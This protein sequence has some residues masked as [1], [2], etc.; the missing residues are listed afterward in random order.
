MDGERPEVQHV[1]PGE[2]VPLFHHDHF[3]SQVGKFNGSA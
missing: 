2:G 3:G 1:I